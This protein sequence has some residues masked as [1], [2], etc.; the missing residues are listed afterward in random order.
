VTFVAAV[1]QGAAGFGFGLLALPAVMAILGSSD[2][3]P[4]VIILNLVICSGLAMKIRTSVD[5]VLMVRMAIGAIAGFPV[6]LY[7][8]QRADARQLLIVVSALVLAFAGYLMVRGP[9]GSQEQE[10]GSAGPTPRMFS[11]AAVGASASAMAIALGMPG[12]PVMLYL[13]GLGVP[14]DV[15]RATALTFFAIAY[16]G[17]LVLQ[18]AV[19]GVP[20]GVW[21][22]GGV[23]VPVALGGGWVGD[24]LSRRVD[25]ALFRSCV[26]VL[27]GLAGATAL[28]SALTR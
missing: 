22:S 16:A 10:P 6:G 27:I 26:L 11:A 24:R 17:A 2:A 25:E 3:V 9:R 20:S 7:V 4:L 1:V 23:L 28:L 14:K 12:P 15:L 21:V 19:V 18:A 5:R 13:A 8:F